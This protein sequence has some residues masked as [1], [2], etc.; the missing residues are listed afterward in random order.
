MNV[1]IPAQVLKLDDKTYT[2]RLFDGYGEPILQ[3]HKKYAIPW[4]ALRKRRKKS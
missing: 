2:V 1:L 3:V 4:C